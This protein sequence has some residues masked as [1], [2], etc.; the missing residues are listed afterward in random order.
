[1]PLIELDLTAIQQV[2]SDLAQQRDAQRKVGAQHRQ[3]R[4]ELEALR[5]AGVDAQEIER[6]QQ[7]LAALADAAR[8]TDASARESLAAIRGLSERLR[9]AR[10]PALMVQALSSRYPVMLMPVAVQ[11]RY[12]DATTR[13]MIHIY[14][15]T[16]HGFTHDPGLTPSEIDEGKRYWSARFVNPADALSPWTQIARIFGP[17]RAAYVVRT[18]T[19]TNVDEIGNAAQPKFDDAAIPL[20]SGQSKP[21]FAQALPDASSRSGCATVKRSSASGARWSPTSSPCRRSSTRCWSR[22]PTTSTLSPATGRGWST[23]TRRK[24]PAWRSP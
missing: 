5:R 7:Q 10:D 21:V 13:L 11:T 14:P 23:T 24:R 18:T 17:S 16:L 8:A 15:D 9:H 22:T 20:A 4:T 1:M 6:R 12:D 3:A 2:R 19:P